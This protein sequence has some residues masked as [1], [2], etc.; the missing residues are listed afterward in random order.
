MVWDK[1]GDLVSGADSFNKAIAKLRK[2]LSIELGLRFHRFIERGDLKLFIREQSDGSAGVL[3]ELLPLDP[4][5]YRGAPGAPG[6]PIKFPI[7]LEYGKSLGIEA[8]IWPPKSK[9]SNYKLG[10]GTVV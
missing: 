8:H 2:D 4:F 5:G 1:L 6:Y 7:S 9:D 10:A 3:E